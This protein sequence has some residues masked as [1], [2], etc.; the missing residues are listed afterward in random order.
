[1]R[2]VGYSL[3]AGFCAG[4]VVVGAVEQ[5]SVVPPR[6]SVTSFPL[7]QKTAVESA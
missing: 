7:F 5:V 6:Y 1:M 2:A 4:S 3:P